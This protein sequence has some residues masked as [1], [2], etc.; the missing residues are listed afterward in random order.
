MPE[1]I[2]TYLADTIDAGGGISEGLAR[3]VADLSIAAT[4]ITE[5][6]DDA[7]DYAIALVPPG[8]TVHEID[9]TKQRPAPRR[10]KGRVVVHDTA[11]FLSLLTRFASPTTIVY[12]DSTATSAAIAVFDDHADTPGWREHTAELALRLTTEGQAVRSALGK[13]THETLATLVDDLMHVIVEPAAADLADA[14]SELQI[15]ESASVKSV[16]RLDASNV[17][18][19]TN[20]ESQAGSKNLTPVPTAMSLHLALFEGSD[21]VELVVKMQYRPERDGK[22]VAVHLRCPDLPR[23]I[24][25]VVKA[26]VA[27]VQAASP[28]LVVSG[29]P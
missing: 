2:T 28:V 8:Y 26:E 29:R 10:A 7:G 11:S 27:K 14:L 5:T 21:P 13:V 25:D 15:L 1:A 3:Y 9:R 24:R 23:V 19:S 22:G 16:V 17:A 20:A 12:V 18:L 6:D 4:G